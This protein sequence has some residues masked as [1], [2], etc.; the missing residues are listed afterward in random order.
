MFYVICYDIANP[1]RLGRVA[2]LL[3][4]YG[5]R[6]QESVFECRLDGDHLRRLKAE[7]AREIDGERDRVR[8]YAMC[9]KDRRASLVDGRGVICGE[10]DVI[11]I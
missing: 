11:I 2:R 8:F 4:G 10:R 7:L 1:R 5:E 9:E 3:E 6:V